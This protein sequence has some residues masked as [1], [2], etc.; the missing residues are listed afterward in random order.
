MTREAII[1]PI[2][3]CPEKQTLAGCAGG[4]REGGTM[5][6]TARSQTPAFAFGWAAASVDQ[7]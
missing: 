5:Q 6:P 7:L 2:A 1:K 4:E 3:I